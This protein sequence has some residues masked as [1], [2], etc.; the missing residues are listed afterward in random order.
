LRW[1][2]GHASRRDADALVAKARAEHLGRTPDVAR[3][4]Q[5]RSQAGSRREEAALDLREI[6]RAVTAPL[7]QENERVRTVEGV[8]IAL[9][10]D[11]IVP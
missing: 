5:H 9:L 1:P 6:R 4:D 8:V 3:V 2:I 7:R 10:D 11:E